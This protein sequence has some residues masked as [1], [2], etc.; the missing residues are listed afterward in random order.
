MSVAKERVVEAIV[1]EKCES[2]VGGEKVVMMS[3]KDVQASL[4]E[5]PNFFFSYKDKS[6]NAEYRK[7]SMVESC[8]CC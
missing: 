5:N 6:R 8:R 2:I 4:A 3:K 7:I 1:C